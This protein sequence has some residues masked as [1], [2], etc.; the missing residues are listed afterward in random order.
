MWVMKWKPLHSGSTRRPL[1]ILAQYPAVA[2][3]ES[4]K[5]MPRL[6]FRSPGSFTQLTLVL[7]RKTLE[8]MF[9]DILKH[10]R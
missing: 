3:A 2:D 1:I 9:V 7:F 5:P 8:A 4:I 10:T 6:S